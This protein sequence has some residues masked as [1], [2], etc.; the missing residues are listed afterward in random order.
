M[1]DAEDA[2]EDEIRPAPEVARRSLALFAVVGTA[3]GV[4]RDEIISWL[5]TEGLWGALTPREVAY[6]EQT[7]PPRKAHINF[8]WQ[9]ERLTVLLWALGKIQ[10]L[11]D[12]AMQCDTGVFKSVL[13]PFAKTSAQ[14]FIER[15]TLID[16]DRLWKQAELYLDDHWKAR[17]ARLHER[18]MRL[19]IDIEIEIV[20]ERH[21][22]INWIT[23][24]GDLPWDEVTT[25]T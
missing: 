6:L 23:G 14:A 2:V 5:R 22:A 11:P 15:A 13:P 20:Q 7:N 12:S 18:S 25:D 17:D 10:E 24:Y 8:G 21:H 16:E 1:N 4:P 19:G 9:S 3:L